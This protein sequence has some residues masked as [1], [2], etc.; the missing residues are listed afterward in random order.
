MSGV[1]VGWDI[2]KERGELGKEVK[3]T[4]GILL[5]GWESKVTFGEAR[6]IFLVGGDE[7]LLDR[8]LGRHC[9]VDLGFAIYI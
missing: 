2:G 9:G 5:G 1:R 4:D 6:R 3:H 8:G 7:V